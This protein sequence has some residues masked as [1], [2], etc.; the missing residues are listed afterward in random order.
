[1]ALN[2]GAGV[3]LV[4][5]LIGASGHAR[6]RRVVGGVVGIR[7]AAAGGGELAGP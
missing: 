6:A 3:G 2:L 1:M 5:L 7:L 4:S